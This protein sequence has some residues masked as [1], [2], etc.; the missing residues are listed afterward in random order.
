MYVAHFPQQLSAWDE[1]VHCMHWEMLCSFLDQVYTSSRNLQNNLKCF[2]GFI[3]LLHPG[4][5]I[6]NKNFLV[7]SCIEILNPEFKLGTFY[8]S[9]LKTRTFV[10]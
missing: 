7:W 5:Q 6:Q 4:E 2:A 10:V 3:L 8:L 1:K 9:T